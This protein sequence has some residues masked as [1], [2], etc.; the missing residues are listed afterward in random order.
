[1][2]QRKQTVFLLL[3]IAAIILCLLFPVAKF[4]PAELGGI[5][6]TVYNI[7]IVA[8]TAYKFGLSSALAVLLSLAGITSVVAIFTFK[9]RKS[10]MRLCSLSM[11][12]LALWY[13][14]L[15]LSILN[16][17]NSQT[18]I[19]LAFGACLPLVAFILVWL[20][21]RGVKADDDLVR[22]MDRIR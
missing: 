2:W 9:N 21:R 19:S 5:G 13:V 18:N 4:E 6:S 12:F 10:Q 1:M 11:L 20:A 17:G 7:G 14:W 16:A 3:S 15:A 22:S 8:G